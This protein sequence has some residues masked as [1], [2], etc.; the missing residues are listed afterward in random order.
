MDA[1][2]DLRCGQRDIMLRHRKLPSFQLKARRARRE[3]VDA[4]RYAALSRARTRRT[5]SSTRAYR[6]PLHPSMKVR[7]LADVALTRRPKQ[8]CAASRR[9]SVRARERASVRSNR[10]APLARSARRFALSGDEVSGVPA[11]D[12]ARTSAQRRHGEAHPGGKPAR[13]VWESRGGSAQRRA[14][15]PRFWLPSALARFVRTALE[16]SSKRCAARGANAG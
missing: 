15:V 9:A 7:R 5:S 16:I 12:R 4:R 8:R 6:A 14:R 10:P 3:T 1:L 2:F 13:C 11:H